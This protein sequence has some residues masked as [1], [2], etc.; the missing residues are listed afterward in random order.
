MTEASP[1]PPGRPGGLPSGALAKLIERRKGTGIPRREPGLAVPLTGTQ[2]RLWFLDQAGQD[3]AAYLC[4]AGNRLTGPLETAALRA[5]LAA[6][7]ARHEALRTA[8]VEGPSGRPVQVVRDLAELDLDALLELASVPP[9]SGEEAARRLADAFV[10]RPFALDRPPLMRAL[11]VELAPD[12]HVLLLCLHHIVCD[13]PSLEVILDEVYAALAG[14]RQDPALPAQFPDYAA[15]LAGRGGKRLEA[16][17]RYWRRQLAGAPALLDLPSDRPRPPAPSGRG[18]RHSLPLPRELALRLIEFTGR[19]RSTPFMLVTAALAVTLARHAD[20]DDI[21]IGTPADS[22]DLQELERSVGMYANTVA[23]RFG[24]DGN[25]T[26]A[27]VLGQVRTVATEGL[28]HRMAPFEEVVGL[29]GGRRDLSHNPV[30]QVMLVVERAARR[31]PSTAA[32]LTVDGWALPVPAARFD[33]TVVAVTGPETFELHLDYAK[34]LFDEGTAAAMAERLAAVLEALVTDEDQRMWHV[35]LPSPEPPAQ[36]PRTEEAAWESVVDRIAGW[37]ARTP[38]APAVVGEEG[39]LGYGE[40]LVRADQLADRL[41][42]V[43]AKGE[44]DQIVGLVLPAGAEA[45]VAVLAVLRAGAAYLPLDPKHPPARLAALLGEASAAAVIVAPGLETAVGDYDGPILSSDFSSSSLTAPTETAPTETAPTEISPRRLATASAEAAS[46]RS[47]GSSAGPGTSFAG[48]SGPRDVGPDDLAYVIYTSGS[49]GAPKGVMVTHGT[50]DRLTRS[51]ADVHGFGPGQRLLMLPPLTFDASVGDLFPALTTGAAVVPH[52]E[53]ARLDGAE[54]VR[55]CRE[56]G[57]TAVDTAASLWRRWVGDLAATGVPDDWPVR[58]MMIGGEEARAEDVRAWQRIT[59]GR[60]DLY[61]HYGPTE[62]TVCATVHRLGGGDD[63]GALWRVPI[64]TPLPHVTARVLDRHGG[65]APVGVVGELHLGGDCLARGYLG[66]QDLTADRFAPDPYG[67]PG[68][69]LYRTGDLARMRRDGSLEFCGRRDRQVKIRGHRVE[70]AEVEAAIAAHPGIADVAVIAKDDRLIAYLAPAPPTTSASPTTPTIPVELGG[71]VVLAADAVGGSGEPGAGEW[72]GG[73]LEGLRRRL[74]DRLPGHLLPSQLIV[75]PAIP[76][77]AHGK[78]DQAALPPPD[79]R[80][81]EHVPPVGDVETTLARVWARALRVPE[82]GRTDNFFELGGHSLLAASVVAQVRRVLGVEVPLRALLESA[83]LSDLAALI[84]GH[85]VTEDDP[86]LTAEAV[87]PADLATLARPHEVLAPPATSPSAVLVTGA[88]GF[89]GAHLVAQ[90][91]VRTD[92]DILC[93]VRASDEREATARVLDN[94]RSHGLEADPARIVG[95]PGDLAQE[96]YGMTPDAFAALARRTEVIC[97]NGGRVNFAE[98]YA[99]LRPVNVGGTL[100]AMRL[101]ALAGA[102]LHLVSTLGVF[103]GDA[104]RGRP[105]TE[106]DPPDDP[107]GLGSGYD[108]SKWVADRLAREGRTAG[109][110]VSVHRPAR[111]SGDSRTGRGNAGDYFSRLLATCAALG[112][113]PDLP[114]EEDLAPVD[115]VAAGI[116][117]LA[118]TSDAD[119]EHHYSNHHYFNGATIS[120]TGIARAMGADL[121]PWGR[122]RSAVLEGGERLPLAPF[123][124]TLPEATPRFE[125]PLFD[126]GR[127]EKLLSAAGITCPP[128]DAALLNRYLDHL[129]AGRE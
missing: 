64:G 89:L 79:R 82:V 92:A 121:V 11:L 57:V 113:V 95:V 55:F 77:T 26:L 37:A 8:I 126:C 25:P 108:R 72:E 91:A 120:Y 117:H 3:A 47:E 18:A 38:E 124:A 116:A 44:P 59:A 80:T 129:G 85:R 42:T 70:P 93:L 68:S 75:V 22:R 15:W 106:L 43:L 109:L 5:A 30:F 27:E 105:V 20:Q 60:C 7:V 94:L 61:N 74:R 100:E 104:Y 28:D 102:R 71:S 58:I 84:E 34:D 39:T 40:L 115:Y 87:L 54:L 81:G 83:D 107:E 69:R 35:P 66:R 76:R 51:F 10:A 112:A 101:A 103:L 12:D 48:G 4:W 127:T 23:L 90:L 78:V 63:L 99:R 65:L 119:D 32:G 33:L 2:E 97:H 96:R 14:E 114:F 110:R 6:V 50:L 118:V 45:V 49:T 62:A 21:V 73:V 41:R 29:V 128:A 122:W 9:P 52:A 19:R 16:D 46:S 111:V 53:P 86:D 88:T 13:G 17:L 98:S 24:L 56:H 67:P 1:S 31:R 125:R 123:A 36:P